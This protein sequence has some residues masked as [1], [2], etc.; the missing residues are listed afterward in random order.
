M[1]PRIEIPSAAAR[2]RVPHWPIFAANPTVDY[3]RASTDHHDDLVGVDSN[4]RCVARRCRAAAM[5]PYAM[6]RSEPRESLGVGV[7]RDVE[8]AA[9]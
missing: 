4:S 7:E 8:D 6:T 3:R 2:G 1:I 5:R 9:S